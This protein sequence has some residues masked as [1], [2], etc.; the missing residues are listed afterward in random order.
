MKAAINSI[1]SELEQT[2]TKRVY[3]VLASVNKQTQVLRE[4]LNACTDGTQP[5][6]LEPVNNR[7]RRLCEEIDDTEKDL[8]KT[9]A[10]TKEELHEELRL[11]IQ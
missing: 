5:G 11:R 8:H 4:E 6:L 3:D 1:R 2:I 10:G 9:T 7:A